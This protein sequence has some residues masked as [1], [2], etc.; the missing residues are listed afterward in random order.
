MCRTHY[1]TDKQIAN[2]QSIA[3]S[4]IL[5]PHTEHTCNQQLREAQTILREAV[6]DH[7]KN[8]LDEQHNRI[9]QLALDTDP[10]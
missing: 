9:N 2:L 1:N 5:I 4:T 7:R 6:K 8:R 3:G 10:A